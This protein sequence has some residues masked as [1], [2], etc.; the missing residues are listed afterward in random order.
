M[1]GMNAGIKINNTINDALDDE[2]LGSSAISKYILDYLSEL[3]VKSFLV[4]ENYI[5]KDYLI[6]FSKFYSR[7]F[8]DC[9]KFTKR[10]HFFSEN[11]ERQEIANALEN[12][13]SEANTRIE[14]SYLGFAVVRPIKDRLGN[15]II[16]RTLLKPYNEFVDGSEGTKRILLTDQ[17][18][19]NIFGKQLELETLP[20]QTQDQA[21]GACAT[22]ACWIAQCALTNIFGIEKI[23][24]IEITEISVAFPALSRNIPSDGLTYPQIKAFFNTVGLDTEFIDPN[25]IRSKPYY[26]N[27]GS[28]IVADIAKGYLTDLKIPII[29][30]LR[31]VDE[32]NNVVA[33]HA[34]VIS[35][36]RHKNGVVERLYVHDDQIGPYSRVFPVRDFLSWDNT[37]SKKPGI[38]ELTVNRLIVPLYP[39]IR[40]SFANI[41]A[42][43]LQ[44]YKP[45]LEA[46]RASPG[47]DSGVRFELFITEVKRY[48]QFIR[49]H[50]IKDKIAILSKP[51]PRFLW[52]IRLQSPTK[53][54]ADFV[55][56]ATSVFTTE[57]FDHIR[58]TT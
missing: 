1:P 40:H 31:I 44:H 26:R 29:V 55:F 46:I 16:G 30:G 49:K 13:N 3:G 37:W 41:Y 18:A 43:F 57:P 38:K 42:I 27:T 19:V 35:G 48:K 34:A 36:Y 39:K 52:I 8:G 32:N 17:Y 23:S 47:F 12:E 14:E 56:D 7:S 5:D 11:F 24:P 22:T 45:R 6:D 20:F 53:I 58:Y 25:V 4:E 33:M 51:Y 50:S 10:I 2:Y 54:Y 28:D 9:K 21:V 15:N